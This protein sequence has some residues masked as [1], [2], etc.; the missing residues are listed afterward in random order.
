MVIRI[1]NNKFVLFLG[2][3]SEE[4]RRGE[5]GKKPS[6]KWA[7][8]VYLKCTNQWSTCKYVSRPFIHI[9]FECH[10]VYQCNRIF[11]TKNILK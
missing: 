9:V 5:K 6:R 1:E 10:K 7:F 11:F 4:N 2:K 3:S 8:R